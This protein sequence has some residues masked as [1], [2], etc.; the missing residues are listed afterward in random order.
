MSPKTTPWSVAAIPLQTGRRVLITGANSGI[1]WPT[2]LWLAR[3]GATVMLA[4]RDQAKGEA[5]VTK[6]LDEA[7]NAHISLELLDLA[8][9][10]S[11]RALAH[12][13]LERGLP[14]DLL[15]NNA[16]VMTPPRRQETKDGFELQ[17]GTNVL[18]HFALTGL[19]MPALERAAA[20]A[21]SEE[22]RPRVVTLASIAHKRGKLKFDDL[23]AKQNYSPMESYQQSKLADLMFALELERRL[24]AKSSAI[25]SVA[26]HPGVAQTNLFVTGDY[27]GFELTVRKAVGHLIGTL[28]NSETEG[29][30]PTLYAATSP[31]VVGGGYYG[32]QGFEEM[33]GG[34]AGPAKIAPQALDTGAA[35]RLWSV[36]EELT[37]VRFSA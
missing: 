28:L 31:E 8:S 17:F 37:G 14:L 3:R 10:D 21:I 26:A 1:G 5:A 12:R 6:L 20:K 2:A 22:T 11:V 15:I 13:E 19:L 34:D 27:G 29:A 7:P 24:Q 32:P 36:C 30:Y 16:G 18:G 35:G 23:Q 4:C 9:L 33:R 25:L